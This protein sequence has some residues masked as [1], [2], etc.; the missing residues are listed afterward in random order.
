MKTRYFIGLI[1]IAIGV[2]WITLVTQFLLINI[3]P[4]QLVDPEIWGQQVYLPSAAVSVIIYLSLLAIWVYC[5]YHQRYRTSN[6]A[7][8]ARGQWFLILAI[9]I[10]ANILT[11]IL[12]ITFS[13]VQYPANIQN[14]AGSSFVQW[15]PYEFLI[16]LTLINS[17]LLYW[18]PSCFISQRT[19][20]FIPPLSYELINLTEKR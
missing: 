15:P 1:L 13:E 6:E 18:L 3:L 17:L 5:T 8:L 12:F 19:L 14:T 10:G 7:R 20:R 2:S 4:V 9:G 11:L 16:P